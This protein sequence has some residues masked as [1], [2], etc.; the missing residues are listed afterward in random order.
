MLTQPSRFNIVLLIALELL[1]TA[2]AA[3][4]LM[5]MAEPLARPERALG[6]AQRYVV[7]EKELSLMPPHPNLLPEG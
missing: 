3:F 6:L 1:F 5:Q 4:A 7:A 2:V